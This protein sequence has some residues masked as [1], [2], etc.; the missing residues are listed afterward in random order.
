MDDLQLHDL[1]IRIPTEGLCGLIDNLRGDLL[2]MYRFVERGDAVPMGIAQSIERQ[3]LLMLDAIS[4]EIRRAIAEFEL[5]KAVP[6]I[7]DR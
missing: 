5:Y 3:M 4:P 1:A 2:S 7:G 6:K